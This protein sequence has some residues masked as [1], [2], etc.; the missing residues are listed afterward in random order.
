MLLWLAGVR[1]LREGEKA[2]F[3]CQPCQQNRNW[4]WTCSRRTGPLPTMSTPRHHAG[5]G[6]PAPRRYSG[7]VEGALCPLRDLTV[8]IKGLQ[9]VTSSAMSSLMTQNR[10][11]RR[12]LG[13]GV[14]QACTAYREVLSHRIPQSPSM[15]FLFFSTE[16]LCVALVDLE[17]AL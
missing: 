13:R 3:G 16:F 7:Q 2:G 10:G 6:Q 17:F 9:S 12:G 8:A 4:N 15:T 14:A 5:M 11:G 1:Q